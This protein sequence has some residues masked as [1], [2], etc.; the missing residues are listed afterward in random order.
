[1]Q[2]H[3]LDIFAWFWG[4]PRGDGRPRPALADGAWNHVFTQ[5]DFADGEKAL[6]EASFMMQG[7]PLD[8]KFHILGS[9]GSLAWRYAAA[10]SCCTAYGPRRRRAARPWFSI[11]GAKSR[12]DCTPPRRTRFPS[13][14][15]IRLPVLP[16]PSVA[17]C[18]RRNPHPRVAPGVGL[19]MASPRLARRANSSRSGGNK[20]ASD[21]KDRA[22]NGQFPT[23]ANA[24]VPSLADDG[25]RVLHLGQL[26]CHHGELP[27]A[28]LKFSG[29]QIGSAYSVFSLAALVS[30]FFV[31]MVADRFFATERIM[32]VLHLS[33]GALAWMVSWQQSFEPL[34]WLL[35]GSQLCYLPTFALV[36]RFRFTISET[37]E[38]FRRSCV[39]APSASSW[40]AF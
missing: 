22:S 20:R 6:V 15:A 39:G 2:I 38:T 26:V 16:I 1:M 29:S 30:P 10:H 12:W 32:A 40:R 37:P 14:C 28:T 33:G 9:K 34:F 25:H 13:P 27:H 5:V 31:G 36:T 4:P 7:N 8:I 3:D 21:G 35:L 24:H 19:G 17:A 23:C 18:R 11:A